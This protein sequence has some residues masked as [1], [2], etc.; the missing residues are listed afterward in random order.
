MT[1]LVIEF[2]EPLVVEVV[3]SS[4]VELIESLVVETVVGVV[5][6]L[7]V[8]TVVDDCKTEELTS[9]FGAVVNM[10][11]PVVSLVVEVVVVSLVAEL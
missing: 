6:S 10:T 3:E 7:V 4:V 2:V 8:G 1:S 11:E 9:E 5:M